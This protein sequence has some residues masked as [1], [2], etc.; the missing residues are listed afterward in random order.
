MPNATT[1]YI[2]D[3]TVFVAFAERIINSETSN[4]ETIYEFIKSEL[5]AGQQNYS[6]YLWLKNYFTEAICNI[7]PKFNH[8]RLLRELPPETRRVEANYE[9]YVQRFQSL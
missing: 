4:L 1:N 5:Y 8:L 6:K 3:D 7:L 2:D 9:Y